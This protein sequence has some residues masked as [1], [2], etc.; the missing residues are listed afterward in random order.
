M[1]RKL[2]A[3]V[4]ALGLLAGGGGAAALAVAA[5]AAATGTVA[6]ASATTTVPA[7]GPLGSLVAKGTITQ[8]Q[9]T[10]IRDG[11]LRYLR[12]HR[13]DMRRDCTGPGTDRTPWM[14]ENGG[15]LDTVLSRLVKGG[16]LTNAQ[17]SAVTSAFTQWLNAHHGT[18]QHGYGHRGDGGMMGGIGNA[19]MGG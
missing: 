4:A 14:L 19:M 7:Y 8:A 12:D 17:A 3:G 1:N 9:A 15:A 10:A 18:W 5:P 13:Q 11:L 2:L 6:T 16:T